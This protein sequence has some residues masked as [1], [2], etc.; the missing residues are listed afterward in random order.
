MI[1]VKLDNKA[2]NTVAKTLNLG[3][4]QGGGSVIVDALP[5]QGVEGTTYLLR[6]KEES[7]VFKAQAYALLYSNRELPFGN[8]VFIDADFDAL[9]KSI[10]TKLDPSLGEN[11][12]D[13]SEMSN[14]AATLNA[15]SI[16]SEEWDSF[17][18]HYNVAIVTKEEDV[19]QITEDV[20][21]IVQDL[22]KIGIE[23]LGY[24]EYGIASETYL[25]GMSA[26]LNTLT[27]RLIK[28]ND[29]MVGETR[30]VE[31]NSELEPGQTKYSFTE[32]QEEIYG[33]V[34]GTLTDTYKYDRDTLINLGK[35]N[36]YLI[37]LTPVVPE[38]TY[39]YTQYVFDQGVYTVLG[40]DG[41]NKL[42]TVQIKGRTNDSD[43]DP[44][45]LTTQVE[46]NELTNFDDLQT[47]LEE[48]GYIF[49]FSSGEGSGFV[50]QATGTCSNYSITGIYAEYS[51][52]R[53]ICSDGDKHSLRTDELE[54]TYL[55]E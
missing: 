48:K 39:S 21:V 33:A 17:I 45:S 3:G 26:Y 49:Y 25:A 55:G 42:F 31:Y 53:V 47:Y 28:Q 37:T 18:D 50:L 20:N 15:T 11:I 27:N 10:E 35:H 2:K 23:N 54:I 19:L 46:T 36:C 22:G 38:V 30:S 52:V 8:L 9:E 34:V 44:I 1:N 51:D 14:I 16:T 29:K 40:G 4:G 5:A 12:V 43:N 41:G 7:G 24:V 32:W 13:F 6:K